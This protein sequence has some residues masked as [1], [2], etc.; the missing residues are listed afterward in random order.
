MRFDIFE[1]SKLKITMKYFLHYLIP[2]LF[3]TNVSYAQETTEYGIKLGFANSSMVSKGDKNFQF[4]QPGFAIGAYSKIPLKGKFYFQPELLFVR[5]GDVENS[6][7]IVEVGS[8]S[9]CGNG[10][11]DINDGDLGVNPVY[12]ETDCVFDTKTYYL[13]MPL[14]LSYKINKNFSVLVGGEPSVLIKETS[15]VEWELHDEVREEK[16]ESKIDGL[17]VGLIFG[18][19]AHVNRMHLEFRYIRGLLNTYDNHLNI[20]HMNSSVQ[21]SLGYRINKDSSYY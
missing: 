9:W 17:D 16:L 5:K 2:I 6:R 7:G 8:G 13:S 11:F 19:Q 4:S 21:I 20:N 15:Y 1:S 10:G 18:V 14:N 3:I 12:M